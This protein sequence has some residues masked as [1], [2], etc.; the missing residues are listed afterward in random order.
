MSK[1][2]NNYDD[3]IDSR[4]VIERVEELENSSE[5]LNTDELAELLTLQTLA[6][7]AS[8]SPDWKYGETLIRDS[9]FKEYAQEL[10]EECGMVPDNLKWPNTCIDWTQAAWELK[11]DYMSVDFDGEEYWIRA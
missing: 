4:D 5:E 2:I 6:E 9:Y 3:V 1:E 7:E 8:C 11:Q 10:A